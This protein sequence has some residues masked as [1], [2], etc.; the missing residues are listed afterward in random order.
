MKEFIDIAKAKFDFILFDTPPIAVVTDAVVLSPY[1]DGIVLVIQ[2]ETTSKKFI[3]R[4]AQ[5]L[6]DSKARVTGFILNKIT[7]KSGNYHYYYYSRYYG[8]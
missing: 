5:I 1:I 6:K 7:Q 2:N 3:P 4:I 8:K